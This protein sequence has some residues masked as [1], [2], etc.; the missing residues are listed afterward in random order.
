MPTP[1]HHDGAHREII[2]DYFTHPEDPDAVGSYTRAIQVINAE[3]DIE[4]VPSV[5]HAAA[6]AQAQ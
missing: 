5:E 2:T 4:L 3:G 1:S 6:A